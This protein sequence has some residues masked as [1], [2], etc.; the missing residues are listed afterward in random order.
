MV[1]VPLAQMFERLNEFQHAYNFIVF[2]L[3]HVL[4]SLDDDIRSLLLS[5]KCRPHDRRATAE[6]VKCFNR[7]STLCK[8]T[9]LYT[10]RML[11]SRHNCADG[12]TS[13]IQAVSGKGKM[14]QKLTV[15]L[16]RPVQI[17]TNLKCLRQFYRYF[18]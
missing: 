7:E 11:W 17:F 9:L 13:P 2:I 1:W 6:V 16:S 5:Y 15:P 4:I 3:Y 14:F 12:S 10:Y 8:G 18:C